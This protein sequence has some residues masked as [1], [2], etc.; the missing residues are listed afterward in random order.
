[1]RVL[2]LNVWA[3]AEPLA[4]DNGARMEHIGAALQRLE[5]DIA[6]F[7]E[8]WTRS[9]REQLIAAGHR[10]GLV[11]AWQP[12]ATWRGSGLTVLSRSPIRNPRFHAF[13]QAGVAE[14]IHEADYLGRKGFV[15]CVIDTPDGP[16]GLVN[17]HL[18]ADYTRRDRSPYVPYRTAQVVQIAAALRATPYPVLLAGDLNFTESSPEYAIF[19]GLTGLADVAASLDRRRPTW[20]PTNPYT[21]GKPGPAVRID[22]LFQRHG[23]QRSLRPV[24]IER[25]LDQPFPLDGQTAAPSD[26]A[27][28]VGEFESVP[29]G[30]PPARIP[31]APLADARILL[32]AGLEEVQARQRTQRVSGFL[33]L[34][35][36]PLGLAVSRISRRRFLKRAALGA[37]ILAGSL[38]AGRLA[39]SA[40]F[41]P[42]ERAGF[43]DALRS[44]EALANESAAGHRCPTAPSD[45]PP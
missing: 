17:T 4:R 24:S 14:R 28:L 31:C 39:L 11:H 5:L 23:R 38:G 45:S 25:V 8:L 29:G 15:E 27:G 26:H 21:G 35:A 18:Q 2:T 9:A 7:Q 12:E 41:R 44:L 1:M 10:A 30:A 34:S 19:T 42:E 36:L 6:A 43:A 40:A 37:G 13:R 33:G 32:E 20:L 3:L 22:Y 16:V